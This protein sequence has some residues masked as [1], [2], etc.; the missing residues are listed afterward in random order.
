MAR[1]CIF[2]DSIAWGHNDAV[3]GG[4]VHSLRQFF[5]NSHQDISVYN[6]SISGD[7]TRELLKR[8]AIE[9]ATRKPQLVIFAIGTNDCYYF[10]GDAA[11]T[12]VS[13]P[14]FEKNLQTLYA[15]ARKISKK[16]MFIGLMPF[17]ET[18]VQ[19]IPWRR[20]I[21]TSNDNMRKYDT[22]LKEFCEKNALPYIRMMDKI[23]LK[24]LDDGLH[25]NTK[26]HQKMFEAIR[27]F[28]EK[29]KLI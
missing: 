10:H 26:G 13:L 5:L 11:K 17:D 29:K 19:P 1:I 28:I 14:Q 7:S 8:F 4:W 25:P 21:S 20:E 23:G 12:N 22:A 18:L 3:R 6:C 9:A 16:M 2:G 15:K 27:E 24:D